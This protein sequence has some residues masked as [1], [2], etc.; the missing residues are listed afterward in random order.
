MRVGDMTCR[1]RAGIRVRVGVFDAE[2]CLGEGIVP[3]V[4]HGLYPPYISMPNAA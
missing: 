2:C 4:M 3:W 1:G